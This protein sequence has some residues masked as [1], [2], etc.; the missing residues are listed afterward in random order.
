MENRHKLSSG[1]E[2]ARSPESRAASVVKSGL[3]LVSGSINGVETMADPSGNIPHEVPFAVVLDVV[4][5]S[6]VDAV[7]LIPRPE[8]TPT[9]R[10]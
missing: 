2:F 8:T 4:R 7:S 10:I 1:V 6:S 9:L 3:T 5:R